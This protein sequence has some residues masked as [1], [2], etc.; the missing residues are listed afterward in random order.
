MSDVLLGCRFVCVPCVFPQSLC[1]LLSMRPGMQDGGNAGRARGWE[2][3]QIRQ[4]KGGRVGESKGGRKNKGWEAERVGGWES[5]RKS[6]ASNPCKTSRL[7][8]SCSQPL[9]L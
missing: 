3:G 7:I 1:G 8:F 9:T 4:S 2:S 5:T 6:K